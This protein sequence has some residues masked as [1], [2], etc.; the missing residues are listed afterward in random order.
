VN[1]HWHLGQGYYGKRDFANA[2]LWF[3]RAYETAKRTSGRV[4]SP[5]GRLPQSLPG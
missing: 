5:G 2:A 3:D 4:G 1:V